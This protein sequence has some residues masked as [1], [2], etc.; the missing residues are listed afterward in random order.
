L[1]I[2]R[3]RPAKEANRLT[4]LWQEHGPNTYPLDLGQLIDGALRTSDFRGTLETKK[5]NFDSFEGCLLRVQGDDNWTILLNESVENKRR[6]RFTYAHE[7]GHFMC[8]RHLQDRFEDSDTTLNDFNNTIEE[9]AN[10]FASWLLM[11]SNIVR[12][13]FDGID[14]NTPSLSQIGTRFECSLQASALRF[15]SL[16]SEPIAF[17]VSRDGMI[18]WACKS[19]SAPFMTAYKFGDELPEKSHA[20]LCFS[21]L[22]SDLNNSN[23][24]LH[25]NSYTPS[26]ESQY[27]DYSGQGYQYTCVEFER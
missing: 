1:K 20:S 13:E 17:V 5:G 2:K 6:Q 3:I 4:T 18:N 7:L 27:F 19:K 25:W 21:G 12:D 24:G 9:E 8:H 11:P 26:T 16:S 14:W 23:T 15:V 10:T 22:E